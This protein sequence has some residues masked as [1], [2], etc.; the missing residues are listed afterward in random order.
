LGERLTAV[1]AF[2]LAA[3]L[4]GAGLI[5]FQ[6][7][8]SLGAGVN[9]RLEGDL[10]LAAA[11]VSW[12]LYTIIGKPLMGR[13]RPLDYTAATSLLCFIGV[14]AWA[15]PSLSPQAWRAAGA[16]EWLALLYLTVGG[17]LL[18]ALFWNLA[19]RTAQASR[20]A[21]FVFLQ[22]LVGVAL[23]AWLLGEPLSRWT[24]LGATLVLAGMWTAARAAA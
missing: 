17:S 11:G 2:A 24:L 5:A 20:L 4:S 13:V 6:G 23:G 14:A 22:P 18:G 1:K 3:G 10:L 16:L 8:P 19:L 21:N 15:G 9:S 12:S 7:A